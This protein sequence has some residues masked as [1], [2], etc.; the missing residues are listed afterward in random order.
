[1]KM[2]KSVSVS[3]FL[4]NFKAFSKSV[5]CVGVAS[6]LNSVNSLMKPRESG[7]LLPG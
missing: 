6:T 2:E 1:M 7:L 4:H 5:E 3:V